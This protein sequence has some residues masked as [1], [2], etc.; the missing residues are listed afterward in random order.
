MHTTWRVLIATTILLATAGVVIIIIIIANIGPVTRALRC[1]PKSMAA[2]LRALAIW[3]QK[4]KQ[5]T[6]LVIQTYRST[7]EKAA[8]PLFPCQ[9]APFPPPPP[10]GHLPK[11]KSE[12]G[13]HKILTPRLPSHKEKHPWPHRHLRLRS[14]YPRSRRH[15]SLRLEQRWIHRRPPQSSRVHIHRHT[16]PR[17]SSVFCRR[18]RH[19]R[20]THPGSDA[21][22]TKV[23]R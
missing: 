4:A 19:R 7:L 16:S 14:M 12:R 2:K 11:V 23:A 21:E 8:P 5:S 22:E 10:H 1:H 9:S 3:A 13:S 6:R 18:N 20:R 15:Q 17:P